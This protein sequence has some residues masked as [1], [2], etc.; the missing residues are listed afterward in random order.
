MSNVKHGSEPETALM[1]IDVQNGVLGKE[2]ETYN[3]EALLN[4]LVSLIR[5][6]REANVP[7]IYVQHNEVHQLE[8]DTPAWQIHYRLAPRAGDVVVQKRHPDSF[9]D[10][11]LEGELRKMGI[12]NLVIGGLQTEWCVDST[13]RRAFSLGFN[14]TVAEDGHSTMDTT[15]LKASKVVEHHNRIFKGGFARLMKAK[16]IDFMSID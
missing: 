15:V 11:V 5:K 12:R 14:V 16:D 1:I 13:V 8:P 9:H 3:S 2:Q 7:V 10:T 6:A 4:N